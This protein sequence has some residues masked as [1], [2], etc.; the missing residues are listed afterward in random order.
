MQDASRRSRSAISCVL[1]VQVTAPDLHHTPHMHSPALTATVALATRCPPHLMPDHAFGY[2]VTAPDRML[3]PAAPMLAGKDRARPSWRALAA[4]ALG[5]WRTVPVSNRP[6]CAGRCACGAM[7][8][9]GPLSPAIQLARNAFECDD[10]PRPFQSVSCA[11][12]CGCCRPGTGAC[13][14]L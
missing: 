5:G 1:F 9:A 6:A 10:G 14:V 4:A 11:C 12:R 8:N 2:I 13:A 3:A 7:C